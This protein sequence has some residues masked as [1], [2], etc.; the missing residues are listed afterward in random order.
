MVNKKDARNIILGERPDLMLKLERYGVSPLFQENRTYSGC[1][2]RWATEKK[3]PYDEPVYQAIAERLPSGWEELTPDEFSQLIDD[4]DSAIAKKRE[5]PLNVQNPGN[6]TMFNTVTTVT[7]IG[8]ATAVSLLL[9]Q[10]LGKIPAKDEHDLDAGREFSFELML[11]LALS[12]QVI[13]DLLK[14]MSS[15]VDTNEENRE[16]ITTMLKTLAIFFVIFV[17]SKG[18]KEKLILNITRFKPTIEECIDS[19]GNLI[20]DALT[21]GALS[22]QKAKKFGLFLQQAKTALEKEQYEVFFGAYLN[23]LSLANVS[24]EALVKDINKL[25]QL[26]AKLANYLIGEM[27]ELANISTEIQQAI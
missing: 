2:K 25:R 26:T 5:E 17:A 11:D 13:D 16:K 3:P 7:L 14:A 20:S 12:S 10:G 6:V 27:E 19:I 21:S 23:M 9:Q 22:S 4:L 24:H 1:A 8:M 18:E 15:I